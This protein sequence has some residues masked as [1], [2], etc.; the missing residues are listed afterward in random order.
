MRDQY[1]TITIHRLQVAWGHNVLSTF[2]G[3]AVLLWAKLDVSDFPVVITTRMLKWIVFKLQSGNYCNSHTRSMLLLSANRIIVFSFFKWWCAKIWHA[4]TV[5]Q[6]H[7][8]IYSV[9]SMYTVFQTLDSLIKPSMMKKKESWQIH[10]QA[11]VSWTEAKLAFACQLPP[12]TSVCCWLSWRCPR[13]PGT[14]RGGLELKQGEQN[15]THCCT[16]AWLLHTYPPH[17]IYRPPGEGEREREICKK[18]C[19]Y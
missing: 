13:L 7:I 2:Q 14:L 11:K 6:Y 10:C 12:S 15:W 16:R 19:S 9:Q 1:S 8:L 18:I 3:I 17:N 4:I 5:S